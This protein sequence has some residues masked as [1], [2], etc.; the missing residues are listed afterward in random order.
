MSN[1]PSNPNNVDTEDEL[2]SVEE[3][4]GRLDRLWDSDPSL[5]DTDFYDLSGKSIGPYQLRRIIGRGAF[6]VVYLAED[7]QLGREVALK[8]PRPEIL[9][10]DERLRRFRSE[11]ST[12][13]L[14]DHP[15]IVPVYGAEFAGPSP[16][17]VS[18]Y[19][20]GPDLGEWLADRS[21]PV[22]CEAA[23]RF[24]IRLAEAVEY[25]HQQ[26]VLHRDL[27]PGN[28]LL[29]PIV[30]H[31][32]SL[33]DCIP[34][35]TDFGLAKLLQ[36]SL[37]DTRSS[38]MIGT[39]LYMAPE[40][41]LGDSH[42]ESAATDVYAIGTL[43]FELLTGQT[44]REGFGY[45]EGLEKLRVEQAPSLKTIG[46][47]T[48][49][50]LSTI[51]AKC[52]E[53][54]PAERYQSASDLAEELQ[55][56]LDG[57]SIQAKPLGLKGRFLRWTKQSDRLAVAGGF[58]MWYQSTFL[59]W[60]FFCFTMMTRLGYLSEINQKQ[61][62]FD[63][64]LLTLTNHLPQAW[65]GR[66]LSKGKHWSYWAPATV[67]FLILIVVS[68]SSMNPAYVFEYLYPSPLSKIITYSIIIMGSS[69]EFTL[70]LLAF[71]AWL[72]R[73]RERKV[74]RSQVGG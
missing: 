2:P 42:Q 7:E 5:V 10:D 9:L 31:A 36:E 67:S 73:F 26:G 39:P 62:F 58:T 35:L 13:A 63:A 49:D 61:Y 12:A 56:F 4:V 33:D 24:I 32:K 66:R 69:L 64:L 34:R 45:F 74:A 25:A 44:P 71:P 41:L 70:Y 68:Y 15:F 6:G 55:R 60:Y 50:A 30:S 37:H 14:L 52:L 48:P 20:S 43:L 59:V 51:V 38:V 27:K 19:C 23:A 57:D 72:R 18:A 53:R 3:V 22:D 47:E 16:Y 1:D 54:D 29:E 40:Q 28:V 8:L 17:I 21:E 65:L 46:P 11:A